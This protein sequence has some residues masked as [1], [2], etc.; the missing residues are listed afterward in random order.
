MLDFTDPEFWEIDK[1]IKSYFHDKDLNIH[2]IKTDIFSTTKLEEFI[3]SYRE[4]E[5]RKPRNLKLSP[6]FKVLISS[7]KQSISKDAFE[8]YFLPSKNLANH[9]VDE[10][11]F[12]VID[13]PKH[14]YEKYSKRILRYNEVYKNVLESEIFIL[15]LFD[16]ALSTSLFELALAI[17]QKKKVIILTTE[18]K[19]F[20]PRFFR[21]DTPGYIRIV[22]IFSNPNEASEW[23]IEDSEKEFK[24]ELSRQ[25][26]SNE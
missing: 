16:A 6:K 13:Y 22:D 14:P 1:S 24:E 12:E 20:L 11:G 15:F 26:K 17:E 8:K 18:G 4:K 5:G 23:L 7:P 10:L 2:R 9:L 3:N 19:E 21:I 25:N